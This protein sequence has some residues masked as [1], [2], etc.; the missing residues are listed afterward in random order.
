MP[1]MTWQA[2]I[3]LLFFSYPPLYTFRN[4]L[5]F[6]HYITN[7]IKIQLEFI[8]VFPNFIII[9]ETKKSKILTIFKKYVIIII[10]KK[11]ER[12]IL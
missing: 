2:E 4:F 9:S 10:T 12:N 11:H 1:A 3:T 6:I 8:Y 5:N 7:P